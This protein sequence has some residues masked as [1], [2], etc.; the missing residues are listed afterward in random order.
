MSANLLP[1]AT[2][3]CLRMARTTTALVRRFDASLGSQ[4][5]ISFS[6]Y[7]LLRHLNLAPGGRLR[8]VD[9]AECLG[10]TASAVTRALIPLEKIGLVGR[11]SDPRDARVGFAIITPTGSELVDNAETVVNHV[12]SNLVGS[13]RAEL[14][15]LNGALAQMSGNPGASI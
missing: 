6:D 4:H 7:Q 2:E 13:V 5:G 10:L 15:A 12:S 1:P 8:R 3:F 11:E 14:A 9:L